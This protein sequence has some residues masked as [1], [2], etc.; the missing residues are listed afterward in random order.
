LGVG[1]GVEEDLAIGA[2]D[3]CPRDYDGGGPA[4]V[5]DGEVGVV[6][7]DGLGA[8]AEDGAFDYQYQCNCR[9]GGRREYPTL[10]AWL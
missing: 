2:F 6:C 3:G 1:G 5:A 8:A 7:L 10:I 4:V 9:R